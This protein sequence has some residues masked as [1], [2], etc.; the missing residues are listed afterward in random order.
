M[1]KTEISVEGQWLYLPDPFIDDRVVD[2]N[3][4]VT[5]IDKAKWTG[6]FLGTSTDIGPAVFHASGSVNYEGTVSFE[7]KVLD[8]A[9]STLLG[10]GTLKI[11]VAGS[12]SAKVGDEWQGKWVILSGTGNLEALR[13]HGSWWGPG[14]N[15]DI[16]TEY[17]V[18][19]YDGK[20]HFAP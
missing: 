1:K 16:P 20:V 17:G 15:P 4:L 9:T 10:E 8:D 19:D 12:K 6:G 11:S 3:L 18:I 5:V 14:Y 2:G 7:G 13:G